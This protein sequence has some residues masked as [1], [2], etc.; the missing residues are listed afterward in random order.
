MDIRVKIVVILLVVL[1]GSIAVFT[2]SL[3]LNRMYDAPIDH[4]NINSELYKAIQA[5]Y[6]EWIE[7][8]PAQN[9]PNAT[10][11]SY[12]STSSGEEYPVYAEYW[13]TESHVPIFYIPT[14]NDGIGFAAT[15]LGRAGLFYTSSG[16]LPTYGI[17]TVVPI[18]GQ[19]YCYEIS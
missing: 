15:P 13:T 10:K 7:F 6:P 16:E 9:T 2:G 12:F 18:E 5:H 4:C 11:V 19:T 3:V 8:F 14:E 17:D 1:F